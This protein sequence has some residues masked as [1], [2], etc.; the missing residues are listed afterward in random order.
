MDVCLTL[1]LLCN[2]A[3]TACTDKLIQND[4][5]FVELSLERLG[6]N[7]DL[8]DF[9]YAIKANCTVKHV[10]FSGTFA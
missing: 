6:E 8:D 4:P 2:I 10:C 3:V 9:V 5:G 7:F 1:Y